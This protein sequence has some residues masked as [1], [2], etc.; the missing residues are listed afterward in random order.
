MG[1]KVYVQIDTLLKI[2]SDSLHSSKLIPWIGFPTVL[3]VLLLS[4]L[5]W[6]PRANIFWNM[7][8][9]IKLLLFFTVEIIK[10]ITM[11]KKRKR[12]IFYSVLD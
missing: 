4:F 10:T 3:V 8:S 12:G 5:S 7:T 6:L 11:A 1:G 2:S 9:L